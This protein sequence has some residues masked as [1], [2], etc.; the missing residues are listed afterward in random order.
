MW[1]EFFTSKRQEGGP[2]FDDRAINDDPRPKLYLAFFSLV[3]GF[4]LLELFFIRRSKLK[5]EQLGAEQ[6]LEVV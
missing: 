4:G 6:T 2:E 5:K 3:M 1:S